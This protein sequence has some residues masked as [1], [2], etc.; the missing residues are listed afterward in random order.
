LSADLA[1]RPRAF[2]YLARATPP[3]L[4]GIAVAIDYANIGLDPD[5]SL[6]ERFNAVSTAVRLLATIKTEQFIGSVAKLLEDSGLCEM[7]KE[8]NVDVCA[9]G[10]GGGDTAVVKRL[11]D[12]VNACERGDIPITEELVLT[13]AQ[14]VIVVLVPQLK[15]IQHQVL[16]PEETG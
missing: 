12:L 2:K 14:A 10:R 3:P 1:W 6:Y 8:L 9:K 4:T 15:A 5:I 7:F 11:V 16:P 13:L